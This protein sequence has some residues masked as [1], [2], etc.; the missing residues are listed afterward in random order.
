MIQLRYC[1]VKPIDLFQ[2]IWIYYSFSPPWPVL[3][4]RHRQ[5]RRYDWRDVL[6]EPLLALPRTRTC[7]EDIEKDNML[8]YDLPKK[9]KMLA[10]QILKHCYQKMDQVLESQSPCI[11]K[12][13]YTHCPS[14]RMHNRVDGYRWEN[15]KWSNMVVIYA[16]S[17]TISAA[18][19]EAALIQRHKGSSNAKKLFLLYNFYPTHIWGLGL[20]CIYR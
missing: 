12:I 14:W 20:T 4:T 1:K 16:A 18:F 17:D 3:S 2:P 9:P 5:H 10:G 19:V 13:G 11:Y 8:D 6:D 15:A 7:F